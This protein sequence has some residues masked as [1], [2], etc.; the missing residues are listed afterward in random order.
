MANRAET[1]RQLS[2]GDEQR[3]LPAG[4]ESEHLAV[5]DHDEFMKRVNQATKE[6]AGNLKDQGKGKK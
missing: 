1:S 3:E 5:I 6:V 2:T 4:H